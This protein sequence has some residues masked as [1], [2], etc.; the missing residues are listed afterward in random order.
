MRD[1][2][3]SWVHSWRLAA[4][5]QRSRPSCPTVVLSEGAGSC[6]HLLQFYPATKG[7]TLVLNKFQLSEIKFVLG[8]AEEPI[9]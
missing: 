7:C 1:V 3:K 8:R 5:P 2:V 4:L 9:I 6:H